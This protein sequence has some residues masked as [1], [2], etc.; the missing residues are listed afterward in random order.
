MSARRRFLF[1]AALALSSLA[2]CQPAG[3]PGPLDPED[4]SVVIDRVHDPKV[5]SGVAYDQATVDVDRYRGVVVPADAVVERDGPPGRVEIYM[6]KALGYVGDSGERL[7]IRDER[8]MMGCARKAEGD[9]LVLATY[10][11]W[12]TVEGGAWMRVRLRAPAGLRIESRKGLSGPAYVDRPV[13]GT[14]DQEKALLEQGGWEA[15]RDEPDP[16]RTAQPVS[17]P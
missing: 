7:S 11:E 13:K 5:E 8:K 2:G 10:G 6:E 4:A 12:M 1:S 14:P 9:T 3:N 15:I 16:R 17:K